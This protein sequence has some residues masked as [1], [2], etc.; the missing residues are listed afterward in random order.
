MEKS[1]QK[2]LEECDKLQ[3]SLWSYRPLK[4]ETLKSLKEYYR[5]GLTTALSPL[6][7]AERLDGVS[8]CGKKRRLF[9]G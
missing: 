3:Q 4:E 7:D 9:L 8:R 6:V 1:L 2:K 5:V